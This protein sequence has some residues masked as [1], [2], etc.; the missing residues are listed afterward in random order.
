LRRLFKMPKPVASK[1]Y[2]RN[3]GLL[4]DIGN[5]LDGQRGKY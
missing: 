2:Y 1:I 4:T 5:E 3:A